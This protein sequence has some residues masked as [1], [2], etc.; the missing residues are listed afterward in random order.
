MIIDPDSIIWGGVSIFA[1]AAVFGRP[2]FELWSQHEQK[3]AAIRQ[4]KNGQALE[5]T[6]S[7][8]ESLQQDLA[9]LRNTT[10]QYDVSVE[11]AL[12]EMLH[13]LERLESLSRSK[14]NG[15]SYEANQT[16][17]SA[18]VQKMKIGG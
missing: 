2:F 3:M 1:I 11:R 9:D 6:A 7:E 15:A 8:I 17:E 5:A 4:P 10:T 18:P 16:E 13:R 14:Q 12:A